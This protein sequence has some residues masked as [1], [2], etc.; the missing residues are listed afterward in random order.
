M[1]DGLLRFVDNLGVTFG[2][3]LA[4]A[5]GCVVGTAACLAWPADHPGGWTRDEARKDGMQRMTVGEF[6]HRVTLRT[7]QG[8][9]FLLLSAANLALAAAVPFLPEKARA[10]EMA[11]FLWF[12]P[13]FLFIYHVA[14]FW[15]FGSS[16]FS[17]F[18]L[19]IAAMLPAWKMFVVD[20]LGIR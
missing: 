19:S 13:L 10:G 3:A 17:L 11:P 20:L 14:T 5:A 4:I 7:R 6:F 1:A 16:W 15:K 9:L 2:F 8:K 18:V 12:W